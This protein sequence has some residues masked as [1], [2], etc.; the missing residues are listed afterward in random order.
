MELGAV[1]GQPPARHHRPGRGARAPHW[2]LLD[3]CC[4]NP[5][6]AQRIAVLKACLAVL[7]RDQVELLLGKREFVSH[8]WFK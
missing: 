1:S 4:G 3:D 2:H 5:N 8:S 7:G 6:A